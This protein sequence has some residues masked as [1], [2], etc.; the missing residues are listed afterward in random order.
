MSTLDEKRILLKRE[1]LKRELLK[2]SPKSTS[3]ESMAQ[4]IAEEKEKTFK[5][6]PLSDR[7]LAGA[8]KTAYSMSVAPLK[9][10]FGQGEEV[11]DTMAEYNQAS[12]G[13]VASKVG[14]FA[15]DMAILATPTGIAGNMARGA[16][17]L[18]QAGRMAGIVRAGVGGAVEGAVSATGHQLQNIGTE[19]DVSLGQAGLETALSS[20]IPVGGKIIA[21]GLRKTVAPS[22]LRI[23]SKP[24]DKLAKSVNPPDYKYQLEKG[25]VP[26]FG[27]FG[28]M[29]EQVEKEVGA[30]ANA[31]DLL[32]SEADVL[33]DIQKAF[34]STRK[35]LA[36]KIGQSPSKGGITRAE[37]D[38]AIQNENDWLMTAMERTADPDLV[39]NP[40]TATEL[41]QLADSKANFMT[42]GKK[43]SE[44]IY[45]GTLRKVIESQIDDAITK[46]GKLTPEKLKQY[47]KHKQDL[48]KL[49]PI[50]KSAE[51][52]YFRTSKNSMIPLIP[53]AMA[54]VG[55]T[56]GGFSGEGGVQNAMMGAVGLG[57]LTKALTSPQG[58]GMLYGLGN[59]GIKNQRVRSAL[60]QGVRSGLQD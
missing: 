40:R 13:D 38:N 30:T 10:L 23:A 59:M 20:A 11:D 42:D 33:I 7:M 15:G 26:K 60:G 22:V 6:M 34:N 12:E 45:N 48:A 9:R 32:A 21:D 46:S 56:V 28:K 58:A 36:K 14:E 44:S 2:Q 18:P 19:G 57:A 1:L 3:S 35:E 43:T 8:G 37:Y 25:L 16:K 24:K 5:E 49:M 31:K 50:K 52:A 51:D 4:R 55:G 54:G 39:A 41:R 53:T 27:G 17:F 29:V 47:I